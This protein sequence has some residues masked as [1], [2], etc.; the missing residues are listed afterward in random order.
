MSDYLPYNDFRV[1]AIFSFDPDPYAIPPTPTVEYPI[2]ENGALVMIIR[3]WLSPYDSAMLFNYLQTTNL[4]WVRPTMSLYN[5]EYVV[6]RDMYF[7]GDAY[8][9]QHSY[10]GQSYTVNAWPGPF[11]YLRDRI[12]NETDV[13]FNA[14]LVQRY[15]PDDYIAYHSD[16][17]ALGKNC[18]VFGV[19]IG[20]TRRFYF[21]RKS[22]G[23]VVKLQVNNGDAMYMLGTTQKLWKHSVPRQKGLPQ[24]VDG[25][26]YSFT[27]RYL[28]TEFDTRP[29]IE[30]PTF[31][32]NIASV[33]DVI[34][35]SRKHTNF[36]SGN[37]EN[38]DINTDNTNSDIELVM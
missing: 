38:K 21:K 20:C 2:D 37:I 11:S 10:S 18:A 35:D 8:V 9:E 19:S 5:K 29:I 16:K 24:G 27:A 25:I 33:V 3:N 30:V 4:P 36:N 22:D 6:P 34:Q 32:I 12:V 7:C 26:R 23:Y 1:D 14:G 28:Q 13:V 17:E 31:D 15:Y